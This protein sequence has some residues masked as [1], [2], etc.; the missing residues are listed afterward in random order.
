MNAG[1]G[2]REINPPLGMSMEGLGQQHG[3][4][5]IHDDLY[6]RACWFEHGGRQM[7]IVAFDLL[8]FDRANTDRLRGAAMRRFDLCGSEL[9]INFSHTHAGPRTSEWHYS[10]RPDP[11]YLD[12]V[13]DRMLD[14]I[15]D[16]RD[17]LSLVTLESGQAVTTLP[18]SRRLL[19]SD[20]TAGWGPS[21][22]GTTC[23]TAPFLI[24]REKTGAVKALLFSA[25]C[26]PSIL[27][28][29][30]V[31]A[32]YPGD[33][34]RRLNASFETNGAMFLQGAAG[35]TKPCVVDGGDRWRPGTWDEMA[36]AGRLVAD[37]IIA[38]K[39]SVVQIEPSISSTL[40]ECDWPLE[41]TPDRAH[42]Q[43]IAND[44]NTPP[45]YAAWAMHQ[46]KRLD[47]G[48]PLPNAMSITCHG[49]QLGT[50]LRMVALEAELSAELGLQI[51]AHFDR[52]ITFALGYSNGCAAYL[53]SDS[54]LPEKGYEVDSYWEYHWPSPLKPGIKERLD[55]VLVRLERDFAKGAGRHV[56]NIA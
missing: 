19:Q 37:P 25:A 40:F 2:C 9:L 49:I 42:F 53:V 6:V 51:H 28:G 21:R 43:S 22:D 15:S 54:Q 20:G 52:G 23:Q 13:Q 44:A 48:E 17:N 14:A 45:D 35:D 56:E 31:S 41:P 38:A 16:A 46:I 32:D 12:Q 30:E 55:D 1:F 18:T 47:M 34:V 27:Y 8:F 24:A 36:E 10:G 26:H 3:I 29:S 50:G 11:V 4:S 5:A 33:A 39:D 7:V